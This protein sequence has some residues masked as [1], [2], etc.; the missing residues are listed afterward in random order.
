MEIIKKKKIPFAKLQQKVLNQGCYISRETCIFPGRR[1]I[2]GNTGKYGK[3]LEIPGNTKFQILKCWKLI[4]LGT[5]NIIG[6][7]SII[8]GSQN[9]FIH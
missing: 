3:Y 2:L 9:S 4:K 8:E 1:E 7:S 6:L 5:K